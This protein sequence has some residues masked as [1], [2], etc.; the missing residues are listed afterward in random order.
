MWQEALA[1]P[2]RLRIDRDST[3]RTGTLYAAD[4]QFVVRD[5]RVTVAVPGHNPL[6]VLGFDVYGQ[7]AARSAAV[8]RDLGFPGG[9]VREGVWQG[10]PVWIVGGRGP[11]DLRSA[12][13]WVEKDR[14]LFVRLLEPT[15]GDTARTTDIRF[16]DYRPAGGGWVAARVEAYTGP[17]RTLVEEYDGVRA[18]VELDPALFEAKKWTTARHWRR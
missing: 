10:Q 9:P 1:V 6:L 11:A 17:T 15:A 16:L 14:L 18:D 13:Y 2:G 4:S 8:L 12:Q 5:G 7:S 3:L